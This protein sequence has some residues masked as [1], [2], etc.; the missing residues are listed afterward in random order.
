[1]R[2]LIDENTAFILVN[3]P[4]NPCGSNYSAAHLKEILAVAEEKHLP[5]LADEIYADLVFGDEIFTPMATV[6][7]LISLMSSVPSS[8]PLLT[9]VVSAFVHVSCR[10][11]CRFSPR[12]VR[13]SAL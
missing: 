5:I 1:M 11:R 2:S 7:F 6:H 3:N 13:P 10:R 8:C 4:S 9:Y 12:A